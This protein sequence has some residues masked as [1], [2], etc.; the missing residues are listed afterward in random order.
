[1]AAGFLASRITIT[2]GAQ[3]AYR[4]AEWADA[5][6]LVECGELELECA[7]GGT[8]RF[9]PGAVLFL[10]GLPLRLLRNCGRESVVLTAIRRNAIRED[11]LPEVI[12]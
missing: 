3:R 10:A 11:R 1:M 6:V 9:A 8:R 4:E 7:S 5:L 2:P 12:E